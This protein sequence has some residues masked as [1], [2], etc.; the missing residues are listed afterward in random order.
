MC[1]AACGRSFLEKS[2]VLTFIGFAL[3]SRKVRCGVNAVKTIKGKVNL[4]ILCKTASK[5]T[6]DDA[7]SLA[8]KLS[9]KLV[10]S[11]DYLIEDIV[12]KECCKLI[13]IEDEGL[14]KAIIEHLDSH[15]TE[16]SGGY[17]K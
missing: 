7:I 12:N 6:Y 16:Y 1:T 5:N 17:V 11:N 9:A 13:A 2:K 4:L 10:I 3:K 8:K 15:F 14:A